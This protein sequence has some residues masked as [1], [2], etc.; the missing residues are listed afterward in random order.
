L[1]LLK[2]RV[3]R[4]VAEIET[5]RPMW[6]SLMSPN[7]S[8]FQSYRWSFLAAKIFGEREE[9]H[10]IVAED[11]NGAA[12]LPLVIQ[13]GSRLLSFAGEALFDYRDYLAIGDP[14][15]LWAAWQKVASIGLPLSITAICRPEM[16]GWENLPK[17]FFSRAPRLHRSQITSEQLVRYHPRAFSRLRKLERMGLRIS[18]YSGNSRI[19][20]GIYRTRTA[21]S[22][23]DE[24]FH[25][26]L[27][28]DF[29][30]AI[31][32]EEGARCEVFALEHGSTLAAAL[33]TFR[34]GDW[35]RFYTTFYD[36]RWARFSPGV[37]LLFEVVRRSLD[38]HIN[39]DLMTGEQPYKMRVAQ[40]AQ[41]LFKVSASATELRELFPTA[42][43]AD[44]A[45]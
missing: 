11:D 38:Q 14:A 31:C 5:L 8:L 45:A 15:S 24:L 25:D 32:S 2:L 1:F 28:A 30:V 41:E 12:I 36:R 4:T 26:P 19:V 23:S 44:F 9:P 18:Q 39:G 3:A 29:M 27:R 42:V 43:T 16:P 17:S 20:S 10:F 6:D 7:L 21:Q 33:V 40:S 13:K 35:R 22:S 34:D 37:T